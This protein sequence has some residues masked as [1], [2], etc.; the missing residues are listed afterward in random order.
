MADPFDVLL[1]ESK[2]KINYI[3]PA[4]LVENSGRYRTGQP[5][6]PNIKHDN[7]FL[8]KFSP[9][10]AT[11]ADRLKLA[12]WI[13]ILEVAEASRPDLADA[14]AAY[15]HFL[16]GNGQ[17]RWIDYERFIESDSAG[18]RILRSILADFV[19]NVEIIGRDRVAFSVISEVYAARNPDTENWQK[20]LGAH[21]LWVVANVRISAYQGKILYDAEIVIHIEDMYNFNPGQSDIATGLPDSA[22]GVFEITGLAKQY[23]NYGSITRGLEWFL[24]EFSL[25][26]D[27]LNQK[28]RGRR[29]SD[30]RRLRNK[31]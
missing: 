11:A 17:R 14:T 27:V 19:K 1:E 26:D 16:F 18:K 31:L 28:N 30:N 21:Y 22:N 29:P 5:E 12:K 25:S 20:T 6:R 8:D 23:V 4:Q 2:P 3:K 10:D 9:R 13:A 24:G 15:R 7:G